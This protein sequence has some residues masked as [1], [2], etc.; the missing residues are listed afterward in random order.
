MQNEWV[1]ASAYQQMPQD[2]VIKIWKMYN[3]FLLEIVCNI[4]VEVLN[5][6]MANG[7]TLAFLV[8]DYVSHLEHHL[9]HIFDDFDFKA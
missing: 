8:E 1:E 5:T 7:H 3:T 4:A 2:T 6:K 9:G